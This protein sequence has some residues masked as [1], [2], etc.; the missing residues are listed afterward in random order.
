[1]IST[2]SIMGFS[3]F[4]LGIAFII[5]SAYLIIEVNDLKRQTN[6]LYMAYNDLFSKVNGLYRK[7]EYGTE[8]PK[9]DMLQDW[10]EDARSNSF[11][12]MEKVEDRLEKLEEENKK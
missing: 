3:V 2:I 8:R 12:I 9:V 7:D 6:G 5:I 1:M 11:D 4:M 10:F